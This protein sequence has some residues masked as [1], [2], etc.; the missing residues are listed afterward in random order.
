VPD[1]VSIP[2][3]FNGPLH[4]GQGGY[5]AGVLAAFV[6]GQ[7]EVSLRRPVPLDRALSVRRDGDGA[8][9]LLDGDELIAD[10]QAAAPLDLD[11]PAPV[12]VEEA[13]AATERYV[14]SRDGPF[15][16]CFV[17]GL[18]R[19]DGFDVFAGEV[20][21]RNVMASPWT[22]PDW[23][24]GDDGVVRPEFVWAALDCPATFA[25]LLGGAV[26]VGFLARFGVRIDAPVVAGAEHVIVGWPIAIEG[27]KYHA[28]SAVFSEDGALLA[29][30]RAL[31]IAPRFTSG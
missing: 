2:A 7:A 4:S 21:G 29:A 6:D 10:A 1:S 30:A 16:R 8:V 18:A 14:G 17:C 23:A 12:G 20:L 26:D 19:D 27:R 11:V 15:S 24:A 9:R 3:R 28:G 31:L 5:S 13:R 22:P 25:P